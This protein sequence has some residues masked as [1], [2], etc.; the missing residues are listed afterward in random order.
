MSTPEARSTIHIFNPEAEYDLASFKTV[1]TPPAKVVE[2]RRRLAL[3]PLR[4]ASAS[5]VVILLDQPLKGPDTN[6][7]EIRII[8]PDEIIGFFDEIR[9]GYYLNY[10]IQPWGWTPSLR[11]KLRV[12]GCPEE[13]LPDH[14]ALIH[15]RELAH[16]RTTITF[17]LAL[18]RR[19]GAAGFDPK[20]FS[21]LPQEFTST[22]DCLRWLDINPDAFLK[23]PLSSSGRGVLPTRSASHKEAIREWCEG[24]IHR[25]RSIM[26]ESAFPGKLDFATE[27]E[28]KN[29]DVHFMGVS[30]FITNCNGRYQANYSVPQDELMKLIREAAPDFNDAY[31]DCQRDTL[32]EI[33]EGYE[34][35][36]GIDMM[37]DSAGAV[38][39]CVE[40]NFR[41]TMGIVEILEKE[42]KK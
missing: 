16:R 3:T 32:K 25:Q 21:P 38:R 28:V 40:L 31:I 39:G 2:L 26:A 15:I 4:Y 18:N 24:A 29:N 30:V 41:M 27:W 14:S 7:D 9:R 36:V 22:E 23:L 34:G 17:N 12:L 6:H 37:A 10:S 5:D 1:Y 19:L 8:P 33:A 42:K 11:H 13:L 35:F 20:H